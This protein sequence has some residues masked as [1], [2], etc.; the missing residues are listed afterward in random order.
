MN[1][2]QSIRS[3]SSIV[4][5]SNLIG[6]NDVNPINDTKNLND[7]TD[8]IVISEQKNKKILVKV[9]IGI[10]L[11]FILSTLICNSFILFVRHKLFTQESVYGISNR[12]HVKICFIVSSVL[13]LILIAL[14]TFLYPFYKS[15]PKC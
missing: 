2:I 3:I 14:M 11:F 4:D 1:N 8:N 9:F 10:T 6:N 13:F 12:F 15:Y 7:K 5:N